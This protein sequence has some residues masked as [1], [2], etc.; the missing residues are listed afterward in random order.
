MDISLIG[1]L[2][3]RD[4]LISPQEISALDGGDATVKTPGK[5]DQ[6]DYIRLRDH[7]QE[8]A[9]QQMQLDEV[10]RSRDI[11]TRNRFKN[12]VL[13]SLREL[14]ISVDEPDIPPLV[15]RLFDDILGYGP[16]EEYFFDGDVTEIKVVGPEIRI[17]RH[18][19]EAL[20]EKRFE[21]I[22]HARTIIERMVAPT[23]RRL[24]LANPRVNA[25]LF[26]GSRLIAH[27]E[28]VAVQGVTATI[29]RF[30][31][32]VTPEK[33]L[34]NGAV[35]RE[36]LEFLRAAVVERFNIV[37][38]GGTGSGK[39]TMLNIL[40]SFIPHEE[41]LITIE[42]PAELQLQHPNVRRL[43]ARPPNIEGKGEVTQ[44]DLMVDALR[45]APK[46]IIIGECRAGEA[47]DMLQAMNT[48]HLGSLTTAHANGAQ[49]CARRLVNMVQMAELELPYEAIIDQIA[50]AI[51]LFVHVVKDKTGRRRIDHVAEVGGVVKSGDNRSIDVSLNTLWRY[52]Q[53]LNKF[54]WCAK[55]FLR[56]DRLKQG[57][58]S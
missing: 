18:G 23:G 25:R 2:A 35:S 8:V 22:G 12:I 11:V 7:V 6:E 38:S 9:R 28:P 36:L 15:Q 46:R 56:A 19:K 32:D 34:R 29:R 58:W 43:E 44:R 42:D 41:S 53:N 17:E 30:R 45:M 27:I 26:D 20:S 5:T 48:G 21:D 51:D 55:E 54:V 37:V 14:G 4:G 16:L 57:G 24:D 33:L 47:F 40:A 31:Q 10:G 50:D 3:A 1:V 52:D 49:H 13:F 39:T